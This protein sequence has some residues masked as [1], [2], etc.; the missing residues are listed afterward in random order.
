MK[1]FIITK[2]CILLVSA[3]LLAQVPF[4]FESGEPARAREINANFSALAKKLD[5]FIQP[6]F[7]N[8]FRGQVGIGTASPNARLSLGDDLGNTKLALFDKSSDNMYGMGVTAGRFR[9]HVNNPKARFS[10]LD[11]VNGNEIFTVQGVGRVGIKVSNPGFNL[12]VNGTAGKPGGGTWATAS[13]ARLKDI[14]HEYTRGLSAIKG[15][16]PVYYRYKAS[17][18]LDLPTEK[19]HIGLVAQEVQKVIPEAV[20]EYEQ[21]YLSLSSDPVIFALLNAVKELDEDNDRLKEEI[22]AMREE[23][24]MI[25][26][27]LADSNEDGPEP[28]L[29]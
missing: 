17:N 7:K 25:K 14:Q 27:A 5:H 1:Y 10:F 18:T 11:K 3:E 20:G 8:H 26:S 6:E 22:Q 9:L 4:E 23:L 12:H 2:L 15:L 29:K 16:N 13:D 28:G 24:E 19:T 21:G